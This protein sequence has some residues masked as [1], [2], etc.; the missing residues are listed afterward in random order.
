VSLDSDVRQMS[1]TRPFN[2]LPR[3]ALQLLAFSCERRQLKAGQTLFV[4]GEPA[5]CAF[6]LLTGEIAM[7]AAGEERLVTPGALIGETALA[8]EVL[9]GA[10]A[11]ASAD[12]TLLR[13]PCETFR[14]V[15]GEFP[16]AAVKV[17]ADAS[18]RTRRF[19]NQLETIRARAFEV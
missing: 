7:S 12:S 17:H 5:D 9:R 6:F 19:L 4:A 13:I 14:R 16:E 11:Q 2:L 10:G 18:K 3:E 8:A 1:L 15:L